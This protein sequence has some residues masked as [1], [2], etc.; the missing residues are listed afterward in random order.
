[1]N[2]N[3]SGLASPERS[4]EFAENNKVTLTINGIAADTS[5]AMYN[6]LVKGAIAGPVKVI[7]KGVG[8]A[9][10]ALSIPF[11]ATWAGLQKGRKLTESAGEVTDKLAWGK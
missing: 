5:R 3:F 2:I 11:G 7:T 8:M 4:S 1:M 6:G 10:G 9:L